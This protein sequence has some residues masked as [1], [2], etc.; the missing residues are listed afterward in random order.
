MKY[1]IF[2]LDNTLYPKE[3][4]LFKLV[5]QRI[6]GYM[7]AKLGIDHD[8]VE[9]LR[10]KYMDRYGTTLGGLIIHHKVD[11]DEYLHYVHDIDL[12]SLLSTNFELCKLLERIAVDKVIFTN[13]SFNHAIRVLKTMGIAN[14]FSR[15]FDI[16]FMGYLAKPNLWSYK[17]VLDVLGVEGGECL[18]VEDLAR[19]LLPA[20][21]LGMTTVLVG[22]EESAGVDFIIE[23]IFGMDRV[24]AEI[25]LNH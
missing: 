25:G 3:I 19:N 8:L 16:K 24:L 22:E 23:D 9:N 18:I 14:Y 11:P 5:D 4:G 6:N 10:L 17:K 20:K 13:G 1:M 15:I 2:D 7:R 21:K 12:E